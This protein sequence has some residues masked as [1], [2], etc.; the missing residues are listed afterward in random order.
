VR[1]GP[2]FGSTRIYAE[3]LMRSGNDQFT[4]QLQ[5]VF[6]PKPKPYTT[7]RLMEVVQL[8]PISDLSDDRS[9]ERRIVL[10]HVEVLAVK[11]ASLSEAAPIADA[12]RSR[13][14]AADQAL[15]LQRLQRSVDVD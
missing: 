6:D 1:R 8:R 2:T 13:V 10:P 12:Q 5:S 7:A 15:F 11:I 9:G 14:G 3:L 4:I